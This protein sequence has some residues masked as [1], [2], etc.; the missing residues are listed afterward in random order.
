MT[1]EGRIRERRDAS[2][3]DG[4]MEKGAKQA[5]I[6]VLARHGEPDLSR[7]IR[8]SAADY[9]AWWA[10]YEEAG[11]LPGQTAPAG[12]LAHADRAG[13]I[14]SS[15]RRRA[16]ETARVVAG[17]RDV[18]AH[19]DLIEAPLPPP[20]WPRWIRFRPRIWGVIARFWWWWFNHHDGHE[21][22]IQA[23]ARADQMAELLIARAETGDNVLVIAHGFFNTMVRLALQR[24][25]WKLVENQGFKYWSF[26]HLEQT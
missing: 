10:T 7:R 1:G 6:I 13:A 3:P 9:A 26:C 17:E 15:T 21:T 12:L 8:L 18:Q 14:F 5:G 2:H 25:G 24:R 20:H 16:I 4:G 23:Q 19:A 11:L 22:R